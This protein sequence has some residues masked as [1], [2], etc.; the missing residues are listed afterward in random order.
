MPGD[1]FRLLLLY[2]NYTDRLSYYD[3]WFDAFSAWPS[4]AVDG[5]DIVRDGRQDE[6][7][8]KLAASDGVVLLHSTN[9]DTTV[10]LDNY[11]R[12]LAERRIP[13]LS[14]V[15][16]EVN[17]PGSPIAAKRATFSVIRPEWV[18]TQLLQEAGEFLFGDVT[19]GVVAIPHA[20][21]PDIYRGSKPS[22][23]R[24][25]DI[26]TRVARYLA[27][28]GDDDR[29]R[30][31]DFFRDNGAAFGLTTDISDA[32]FDRAGWVAFLGDCKGTVAT[33]AGSWF[34]ERDDATVNAIRD[35][36]RQGGGLV[37]IGGYLTFQGIDG[38]ARYRGTAVEEALPVLMEANDDR[39]ER[40]EGVAPRVAAKD[41]P[42]VRGLEASWP[43]LLG[44]NRFQ[45]KAGGT[46]VATAGED[47]LIVAG[48]F[49]KGRSVAFASDCGPHWAPPPF[50][51]WKGYAPLWQQIANWVAGD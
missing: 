19:R 24:P 8:N 11:A 46:V 10:Y 6:L 14:F 23:E 28:L 34:I 51:D 45:A 26:G 15:G 43:S 3:D 35:Y 30:I 29:N 12:V 25:I 49:G 1:R 50:V 37:M 36:V 4:F 39:V 20:L 16:N 18:A 38:K 44:Y 42:I 27:H 7:R 17:L 5:F 21:N 33:E 31:V 32:R 13:L 40:P 22:N 41:H 48:S 9:G 2:A 47:P